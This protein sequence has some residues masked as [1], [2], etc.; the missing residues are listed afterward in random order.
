MSLDT[1]IDVC[2]WLKSVWKSLLRKGGTDVP[3]NKK[4]SSKQPHEIMIVND[5]PNIETRIAILENGVLEDLYC[6]RQKEIT[7]VGNIYK[8]KV[9]N[10][11]PSIQAAFIEYGAEQRGFLH[12]T[13]VHPKYFPGAKQS[14]RV[15]KKI[16]K[17]QRP[18]IQNCFKRG[19]EVLVQ[20]LKEGIGTKGPT[21]TSYLSIPGR[22]T[23]M[24]PYMDRVGVS[25][26]IEDEDQRKKMR[27]ILDSIQLPEGFGFI[28]RTAGVGKSK[29]EVNRDIAYLMRLWS[30]IETRI[31]SVGA[32]CTLYNESDLLVRTVRDVLRPS[33]SEI[34]VDSSS[35]FERIN[36]FLKIAAPRSSRKIVR[37]RKD[38][39]IFHAF[40]IETQIEELHSREVHLKSGGRL[41]IDQT[42]ALVAIDV[43]SGKSR[44]AKN[45]ETNALNTNLEAA[46]EIC[47]QLRLRDLGGIVINDL[48]DMGLAGNRRKVQDRFKLLLKR[49]RAKTSVLPLSRFGLLQMTRQRI[50]P[51]VIDSNY[52]T[53]QS[54]TGTGY[55]KSTDVV[56]S[57]ATRHAGWLLSHKKVRKVELTC[58]PKVA[59]VLLSSK[60]KELDRYE[61]LNSK[62]IVVRVSES[63]AVD[64]IVYYAYDHHG[65]DIE[66]SKLEF[67]APPTV[68]ELIELDK[69]HQES[70]E[71]QK[72]NKKRSRSRRRGRR[73]PPPADASS[74]VDDQSFE[75]ELKQLEK[76]PAKKKQTKASTPADKAMRVYQ[77]A[78]QL[79]KTSKEVIELCEKGDIKLKNHMSTLTEEV[80]TKIRHLLGD[81]QPE[82]KKKRSRGRRRKKPTKKPAQ[83]ALSSSSKQPSKSGNKPKKK[84][85]KR[86]T[87]KKTAVKKAAEVKETKQS[88]PKKTRRTLYG[89][90]RRT[91]SS[92]ELQTNRDDRA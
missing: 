91:L 31:N 88:T 27:K 10:V 51:S 49:D 61:T 46:D 35:A 77:F 4:R 64:R 76:K 13:D 55:V 75:E 7:G 23:V 79:G 42:E 86:N 45:S 72:G 6:E 21:L 71:D 47:R 82:K 15:G 17:H 5:E 53:C 36:S 80:I 9:T 74:I 29:A 2:D 33:I 1:S 84:T 92:E 41:V 38:S 90:R 19:D 89:G 83:E 78:K 8:G 63:L 43:N 20:V 16:A 52:Y 50:R 18:P 12:I 66:L 59:T 54:C 14:E 57:D 28:L 30:M 62:R 85:S 34:I 58:S 48:I 73:K 22:L 69:S 32:P 65:A 39:P 26:K 37:Y 40:G 60:R 44:D 68:K 25:R 67:D 11:E 81:D 56:A 3:V 24:M 87:K 70:D